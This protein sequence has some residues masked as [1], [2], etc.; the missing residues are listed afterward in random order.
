MEKI[1][2]DIVDFIC[3]NLAIDDEDMVEVYKY[4]TEIT[5]SSLINLVMIMI[6][7]LLLRDLIAGALFMISFIFLR[8]YTGGYHAEAYW[9]C[10]VTFV[11]TYILTFMAA[12]A[13]EYSNINS[14]TELIILILAFIPV[15]KYAP[16]KNR[17][18]KLTENKIK[19]SRKIAFAVYELLS[20]LS[21]ILCSFNIW[22]GYM[23]LTTILSV[24]I[25]IIVEVFMQYKGYHIAE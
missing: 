11:I 25:L 4:G 7:S 15:M 21:I 1:S 8:S 12:K 16:V 14:L 5:L 23:I 2:Q 13:F 17:H 19:Q 3:Q 20:V 9:R 10:N 24:S 6:C 22:H 18:K